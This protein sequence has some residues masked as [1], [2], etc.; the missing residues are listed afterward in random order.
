[1]KIGIDIDD[2]TFLTV[3]SMLK[4]ADKFEEEKSGKIIKRNTL[5]LIKNRYY[6]M[7][8]YGWDKET[9]F[10]FF[11]KYYKN[12]LEECTMLPFANKVIQKLKEEGDSIHFITAR[13]MNINDCDT[14]GITKKSLKDNDIP[15]DSL[16]LQISDKLT[17][18]K[19][20]KID[21]CIEDSYETCLELTNNGIKSILMTTKM[22]EN[23]DAKKIERVNNW[24]EIYNKIEQYKNQQ[25]LKRR[26]K[27]SETTGIIYILTNEAMPGLIK[28]GKTKNIK[29]RLQKLDTTG[30][31]LP[32]KLHYAIEVED[33]EQK[34]KFLHRGLSKFRVRTNRE[35]FKFEPEDAMALLQAIGGK[36]V[37]LEYRDVAIDEKGK[38]IIEDYND[39]LPQAPITTFEML[40]IDIGQELTFTRDEKIVC[41]VY[42]NR[43][44]E[45]KGKI[46]SLSNLTREIL[47][48]KYHGRSKHVNGFQ[49]WKYEDE[50]L[51]DRRER[52]ESEEEKAE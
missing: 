41:K 51:V 12:V 40:K 46:Y 31:P 29:E 18:C 22:N 27:M 1:M 9:K 8:I 20:N 42:D 5:G 24:N 26:Q 30:V 49:Y 10:D 47:I 48:S 44:V 15:Y 36:E 38:E 52:L 33:Y 13:L 37:S 35:F 3:K 6:L 4:Y 50:I 7:A 23:I 32:F 43:K 11:N 14:E 45:Y 19:E 25:I 2:T 39:R 17:F 16:N 21:L 28:I 34:E